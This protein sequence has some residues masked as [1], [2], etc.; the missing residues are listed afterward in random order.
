MYLIFNV[1]N[2]DVTILVLQHIFKMI[3]LQNIGYIYFTIYECFNRRHR[4]TTAVE[5][6]QAKTRQQR[7][8]KEILKHS[9]EKQRYPRFV[10]RIYQLIP[11]NINCY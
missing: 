5:F 6:K 8:Q 9:S 2:T 11:S 3:I 7:E 1:K 4:S 10:C